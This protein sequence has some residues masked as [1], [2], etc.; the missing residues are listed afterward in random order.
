M[1]AGIKITAGN[2]ERED[3]IMSLPIE[4][5][6]ILEKRAMDCIDCVIENNEPFACDGNNHCINLFMPEESLTLVREL[7]NIQSDRDYWKSRAELLEHAMSDD[8]RYCV[9]VAKRKAIQS[10]CEEPCRDCCCWDCWTFDEARFAKGDESG[11]NNDK[12]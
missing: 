5:L 7:K 12:I 2:G 4:I 1:A 11:D 10:D 8:C 9:H 3:K 6:N